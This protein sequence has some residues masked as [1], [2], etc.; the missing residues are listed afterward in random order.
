MTLQE[1]LDFLINDGPKILQALLM[2]MGG[3]KIIARYT[4]FKWDD[5]IFDAIEAPFTPKPAPSSPKEDQ[6][7]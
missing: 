2:V 7:D 5:H 1:V 3:L 6:E 4:P